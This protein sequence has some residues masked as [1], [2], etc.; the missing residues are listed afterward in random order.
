MLSSFFV[1]GMFT[2]ERTKE[3]KRGGILGM[4]DAVIDQNRE[5]GEEARRRKKQRS[6]ARTRADKESA[7]ES[8]RN[9]TIANIAQAARC[10]QRSCF[11]AM[12]SFK[13][14]SVEFDD[15]RARSFSTYREWHD[16]DMRAIYTSERLFHDDDRRELIAWAQKEC[17]RYDLRGVMQTLRD[18]EGVPCYGIRFTW[19]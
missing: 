4:L 9:D 17:R 7:L 15:A 5:E 11:V 8:I 10:G 1:R 6:D 16:A 19:N 14:L 12:H 18:D 13:T 2:P 3:G